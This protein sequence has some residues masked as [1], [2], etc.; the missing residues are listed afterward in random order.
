MK[1]PYYGRPEVSNSDLS[2]LKKYWQPEYITYD[3]EQAYRF[4]T[5]ID[6]MITEPEKVDY[7]QLTCAG[8]YYKKEDFERAEEM[9]K[10]F[11]R[12]PLCA[13][14]AKQAVYQKVSIRKRF[15]ISYNGFDFTLDVR[16]KWDLFIEQISSPSGDI[17]STTATTQK[18]FE[19]AV[20]YFDYDRQR[21][22]YMDI[23][24]RNKDILIGISKENFKV[25]KVPIVRGSELFYSGRE[26][27][28]E[29]AFK[30]CYLFGDIHN[31]CRRA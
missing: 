7:F 20:R 24:G 25:F 13:L 31:I 9:K 18:Q 21:A 15:P 3:V 12:D 28:E 10:A 27:Y 5:L 26:K 14:M 6:C 8:N 23:E 11:Y 17:K 1:D 4:G 29:L 22:W 19:E 30:Y 2:W 16:C